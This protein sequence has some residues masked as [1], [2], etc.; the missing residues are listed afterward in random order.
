MPERHNLVLDANGARIADV[1]LTALRRGDDRPVIAVL[2]VNDSF[3][4]ELALDLVPRDLVCELF[5]GEEADE[6]DVDC[7]WAL[8]HEQAMRKLGPLSPRGCASIEQ[9]ALLDL[10]PVV[11]ITDGLLFWAGLPKPYLE[12]PRRVV[13]FSDN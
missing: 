6:I 12:P 1:Y 9:L 10:V 7:V 5:D 8:S 11:V 13:R 3:A 4:R 2:D